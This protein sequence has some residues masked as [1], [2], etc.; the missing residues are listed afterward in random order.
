[1]NG[2]LSLS[3]AVFTLRNVFRYFLCTV[4]YFLSAFS[5]KMATYSLAIDNIYFVISS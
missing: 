4:H 1:M 5:A 2:M 3:P